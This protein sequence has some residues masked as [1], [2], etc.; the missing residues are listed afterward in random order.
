VINDIIGAL[1][2]GTGAAG[3]AGETLPDTFASLMP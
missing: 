3:V 2:D 1:S